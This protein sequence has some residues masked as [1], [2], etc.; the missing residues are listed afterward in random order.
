M[1]L[2]PHP[3]S[4]HLLDP[5]LFSWPFLF[6]MKTQESY[7]RESPLN[8]HVKAHKVMILDENVAGGFLCPG[9]S[10]RTALKLETDFAGGALR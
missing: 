6:K 10:E 2:G 9:K 1:T 5:F 7:S 4:T 8:S 3:W